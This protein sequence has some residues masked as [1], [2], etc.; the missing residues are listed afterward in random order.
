V[1][2]SSIQVRN[3]N[4]CKP[5]VMKKLRV[6]DNRRYLVYDDGSPF[7]YLG[8]TAWELFHRL[9]REEAE[10]YLQ[11]RAA[12][13]FTVVQAVVLAELDGLHT[14]N[15]YGH[16]PLSD[17][18]P[19]KPN[20]A[21]FQHVDWIVNLAKDLGLYIGMLPTWG[22]KWH[23]AW[24]IGPEIFDP[25]NA[26][27]YG[28]WIAHRYDDQPIIWI[29]GGDRTAE[30]E[31]H[32]EI[33][34]AMAAGIRQAAGDNQLITYHPGGPHSF[35][36]MFHN[37][38]WLDFNMVQ[39][40][41]T[42]PH[43][44]NYDM[45]SADYLRRPIKPCMDAESC[46]ENHPVMGP[47]WV[48]QQ[49]GWYTDLAVRQT[50]Y[51][52]LFAGAHGH[53]Y[54]CHPVWQM[55][56]YGLEPVNCPQMPWH[57]AIELP[58]S[59]QMRHVRALIESRPFLSRIPDQDLLVDARS[60]SG[61]E[62]IRATRDIEGT[63]AFIYFPNNQTAVVDLSILTG[64]HIRISWFDPRNGKMRIDAEVG[65]ETPLEITTPTGGPDWVLVLDSVMEP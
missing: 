62:H 64:N 40:G 35:S 61:D 53:T 56:D 43:T 31:T 41:H 47:G 13:D 46:Y 34:R 36:S 55:Y 29:L 54:G 12:Q 3:C 39:S 42:R 27:T 30:K 48:R 59:A 21:Y 38:E 20:E 10:R 8:D 24:G 16:T 25:Q 14:P 58:G 5:R 26:Y 51:W 33:I 17:D 15:P 19:S 37:E 45:V 6:S 49:G 11:N 44:P 65:S 4:I 57:Q 2:Q 9:N 23:Q 60:R 32:T 7:F 50:A 1:L 52:A 28:E 63:Y 22:D 18:D